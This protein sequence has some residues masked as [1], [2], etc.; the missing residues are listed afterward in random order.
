MQDSLKAIGIF[1]IFAFA[2]I[3]LDVAILRQ[4]LGWLLL[5]FVPGF[6]FLKLLKLEEVDQ[7]TTVLYSVGLSVVILMFFGLLLDGVLPLFG[8]ASPL[9]FV[10]LMT[11]IGALV[12]FLFLLCS[13]QKSEG[14]QALSRRKMDYAFLIQLLP[15]LV[16]PALCAFGALYHNV[17]VLE[18]ALIG[19]AVL[20]AGCI[21]A[22]KRIDGRILPLALASISIALLLQA[23]LITSHFMGYDVFSEFYVFKQTQ[24]H[25]L[26]TAPGV[27]ASYTLID[28]LNSILSIT[29]LPAIFTTVLKFDGELFF[30][31]FYPFIFSFVPLVIYRMH[32]D[33][34]GRRAALV[35]AFVFVSLSTVFYGIE[36]LSL[37][38][39]I[40]GQLFFLLSVLL[41]VQNGV[42]IRKRSILLIFFVFALIA[43][44]YSLAYIFVFYVLF[45]FLVPHIKI[46]SHLTNYR[47]PAR[48]LTLSLILIIMA[49]TFSWYI[50]VS[51]SPFNQLINSFN[52]IATFF[53]SDFFNAQSRLSQ[54]AVA[55][56]S[57]TTTSSLVG[58]THKSLIYLENLLIGIGA[59]AVLVKPK[60]FKLND[61]T[62]LS[63]L[64]GLFIL[65]LALAVPNLAST[66]NLTRV[67]SIVLPFLA[68]L[69]VLGCIFLVRLGGTLVSRIPKLRYPR[70][71]NFGVPL[72][73]FILVLIFLFQTGLINHVT[74][75]YPYSYSLDLERREQSNDLNIRADTYGAYFMT[76]EVSSAS[77]LLE[78]ANNTSK[79][80][81]D[82]NSR[83]IFLRGYAL[84]PEDEMLALTNE[85]QLEHQT[86][87]YL[88]Y[89]NV[90]VGVI[91][92]QIGATSQYLNASAIS[93]ILE[94]CNM[95]YS[96]GD[97]N[98]YF[99]P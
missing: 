30:K 49:M 13:M 32:A 18:F 14:E 11:M 47:Q 56:L 90:G 81:A 93:P 91:S 55:S 60:E 82:L 41:I 22:G 53:T 44:H 1:S 51:N 31:L 33:Q 73:A 38:R 63:A 54:P 17:L 9:T 2:S 62:R 39:Q 66:L 96:N 61:P 69:F 65:V 4:V 80:Y 94:D 40:I 45:L 76:Q 25:G 15:L 79:I 24:I 92:E 52:H 99:N 21:V 34:I 6:L 83:S 64:V 35:S 95:I 71:K 16:L 74:N 10:P 3:I 7:L 37:N 68:P 85:T 87:V 57:P 58:L 59:I 36:P 97:A 89:L 88:K 84:V 5:L 8:V 46:L 20:F 43:S 75:D 28:T 19:I 78:N 50:F 98:I 29:I 26:W 77:W 72:A 27:V 67:Y 86:Y 42:S 12:L 70:V 48:I 23:V